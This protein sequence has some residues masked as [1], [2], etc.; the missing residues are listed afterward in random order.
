M[1]KLVVTE[2]VTVDGVM[3]APGGPNEDTEGG[4]EHGGWVAPHFDEELGGRA[5][6]GRFA[7][8]PS[9]SAAAPTRSSRPTGRGSPAT[10]P[11]PPS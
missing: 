2:S 7:P 3:Q 9:C 11:S 6:E 5:V 10:T 8:T 4:F 1:G